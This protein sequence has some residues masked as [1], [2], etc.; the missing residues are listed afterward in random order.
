MKL[1]DRIEKELEKL[2][3]KIEGMETATGKTEA[4]VRP[5]LWADAV[6]VVGGHLDVY[7]KEGKLV[8]R[9]KVTGPDLERW[10]MDADVKK[11]PT[12]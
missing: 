2:D 4:T 7:D 8:A 3:H 12:P 10:L 9:L 1:R 11:D 5:D 6:D